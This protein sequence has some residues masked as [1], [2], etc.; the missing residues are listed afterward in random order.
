MPADRDGYSD[1]MGQKRI[2]VLLF[3][4]ICYGVVLTL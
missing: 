2:E 4:L 1:Q 3:L